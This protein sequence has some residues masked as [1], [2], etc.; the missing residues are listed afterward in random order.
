[1]Q[2]A[3]L[4]LFIFV[5]NKHNMPVIFH[6]YK[7]Y[8][9]V[10]TSRNGRRTHNYVSPGD[11]WFL[12]IPRIITPSKINVNKKYIFYLLTASA[13]N[14]GCCMFVGTYPRIVG[15]FSFVGYNFIYLWLLWRCSEL[16]KILNCWRNRI[17]LIVITGIIFYYS[18]LTWRK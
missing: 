12:K 8:V 14:I 9:Y 3:T 16:M 6:S 17:V 1:M 10:P 7:L 13:L 15:G 11:T 18:V 5:D 2:V 4:L